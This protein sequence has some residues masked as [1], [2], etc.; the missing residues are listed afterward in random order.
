MK[1]LI[2]NDDGYF[3]EGI[4]ALVK[5]LS[6]AH[7]VIVCAPKFNQSCVGHGLTL[8]VPLTVE[9]ASIEGADVKVYAIGGTPADCVRFAISMMDIHPDVVVSGINRAGNIGTDVLYSGTVS[10]ARKFSAFRRSPFR[11][12]RPPMTFSR[13]QQAI[14]RRISASSSAA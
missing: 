13:M 6:K 12:R 5:E 10:A 9:D 1:I 2:T 4:A 7:E 14:L 11:R 8:K 3:A